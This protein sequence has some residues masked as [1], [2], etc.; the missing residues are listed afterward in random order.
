MIKLQATSYKLQTNNGFTLL[1]I[2]LSIAAITIIAGIS[3]PIYQSFQNRNDLDIAAASFAQTA[4]RAEVLAQAV[5]G[6]ISWGVRAQS[7]SITLFKGA[8]YT[9]R[10]T[11]FDEIFTMPSNIIVSGTQEFVFTK[12]TGLPQTT[13]TL[14]LTS[15]NNEARSIVVNS[16]GMV[17]Y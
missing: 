8:S 3:I 17:G 16:K 5:D 13:G 12:F 2:L 1:E 7:G 15:V 6:D 14:T 9:G 10:D 11:S 4:R